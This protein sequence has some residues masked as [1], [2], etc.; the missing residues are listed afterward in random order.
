MLI[1]L[2]KKVYNKQLIRV[3][4][5]FHSKLSFVIVRFLTELSSI[6]KPERFSKLIQPISPIRIG[7]FFIMNVFPW[8]I[9]IR[10]HKLFGFK[11]WGKKIYYHSTQL[12]RNPVFKNKS[13]VFS[14]VR[15]GLL[16]RRAQHFRMSR[17]SFEEHR[18]WTWSISN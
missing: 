8:R 9:I 1:F 14:T 12:R 15:V 3:Q 10:V 18:T 2:N 4:R 13:L 11:I 17:A 6:K 7:P 5:G 16:S